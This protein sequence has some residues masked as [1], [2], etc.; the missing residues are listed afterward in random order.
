MS[1][2]LPPNFVFCLFRIATKV[3]RSQ[4]SNIATL[5]DSEG[6]CH[7]PKQAQS[8]D[9]PLTRMQAELPPK[10][11]SSSLRL[12]HQFARCEKL[13]IALGAACQSWCMTSTLKEYQPRIVHTDV[14]FVRDE[15]TVS[16]LWHLP[17]KDISELLRYLDCGG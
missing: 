11:I 12:L 14:Q 7:Y 1:S 16:F 6:G 3:N 8:L 15:K 5:T 10:I 4:K 13:N 2:K 17:L 9:A